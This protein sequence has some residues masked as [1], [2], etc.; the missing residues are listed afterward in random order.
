MVRRRA[1]GGDRRRER[2]RRCAGLHL[3]RWGERELSL[4]RGERAR[5]GGRDV[6]ARRPGLLPG[7]RLHSHRPRYG[8]GRRARR[9]SRRWPGGRIHRLHRLRRQ[10][11]G[12]LG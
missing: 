2:K 11:R 7:R 5:E 6:H 9:G 10:P 8:G 3:G 4:D 1:L 12:A